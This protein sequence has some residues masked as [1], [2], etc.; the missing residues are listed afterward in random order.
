MTW[1]AHVLK[2]IPRARIKTTD[3]L[4]VILGACIALA[5]S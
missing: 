3:V 2:T 5:V 1:T 4:G